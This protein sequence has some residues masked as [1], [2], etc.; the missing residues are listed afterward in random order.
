MANAP[1][2]WPARRPHVRVRPLVLDLSD[3]HRGTFVRR[4]TFANE[5]GTFDPARSRKVFVRAGALVFSVML[6]IGGAQAPAASAAVATSV[7]TA[8]R[9]DAAGQRLVPA[10]SESWLVLPGELVVPPGLERIVVPVG[11]RDV[12][13]MLATVGE[14]LPP[15]PR[16]VPGDADV[17][18][19]GRRLPARLDFIGVVRP[20]GEDANPMYRWAGRPG[21]WQAVKMDGSTPREE[22]EPL[23]WFLTIE[24][25]GVADGDEVLLGTHPAQVRR[26][27]AITDAPDQ[28]INEGRAIL[29]DAARRVT[30]SPTTFE[31]SLAALRAMDDWPT[32]RWRTRPLLEAIRV[33][34]D[35]SNPRQLAAPRPAVPGE[36][37]R[38]PEDPAPL[39][40]SALWGPG[41]AGEAPEQVA[42][43]LAVQTE[44]SW[45]LAIGRLAGV[46]RSRAEAVAH[47]LLV[48][49]RLGDPELP[50]AFVPAFPGAA[51]PAGTIGAG[52]ADLLAAL[53][54]DRARPDDLTRAADL[55]LA[56]HLRP[57]VILTDPAGGLQPMASVLNP[58]P[59]PVTAENGVGGLIEI[60]AATILTLPMAVDRP[61]PDP[62]DGPASSRPRPGG[63]MAITN[64]DGVLF[65][66]PV[67]VDPV[68][69]VPPGHAMTLIPEWTLPDLQAGAMTTPG[70]SAFL[71]RRD[72]DPRGPALQGW[73]LTIE[74]A[75]LASPA[76]SSTP[77]AD[78]AHQAQPDRPAT[79]APGM[80][81]LSDRVTVYVGSGPGREWISVDS[82]G[83]VWASRPAL[84][85]PAA[86]P[87]VEPGV[88]LDAGTRGWSV[89][90]P[91]PES[92]IP[93]SGVLRLGILREH[94]WRRESF[95]GGV[96]PWVSEPGSV[97][98]NLNG[99][100]ASPR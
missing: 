27:A 15:V 18:H 85:P 29:E 91:I 40:V 69:V 88:L 1:A 13:W 34:T 8:V 70:Q 89:D 32:E 81:A 61:R 31:P 47:R 50:G 95:P 10:G 30:S 45:A 67:V 83:R 53:L 16:F 12:A 82:T 65:A 98:F 54:L 97:M 11:F 64:V 21:R 93:A 60:P 19:A 92:V 68:R 39:S 38:L 17:W 58:R 79:D 73:R 55:W 14:P 72:A 84:V 77:G 57:V 90:L 94:T 2:T 33:G 41:R 42:D 46:S 4:A 51:G 78:G 35:S 23:G 96:M 87:V 76:G 52:T 25:S 22:V 3:V 26:L 9:A 24:L 71:L 75:D 86:L 28:V 36:V 99:W 6:A 44:R 100:D 49:A 20:Q 80:P 63:P 59:V 56:E 74:C 7:S 62:D 48:L 66:L 37:R 43:L 5:I